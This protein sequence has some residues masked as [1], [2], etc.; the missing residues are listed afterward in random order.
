MPFRWLADLVVVLH[1]LF[2]AFALFGGLLARRWPRAAWLHLPAAAW[3]VLM[4]YAGWPCPL[5]PLEQWLRRQAGEAGY[6]GGFVEH[7]LLPLLY[8]PELPPPTRWLLG[9]VVLA[10]NAA[11]Y[12]CGWRRGR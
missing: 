9:S 8:P 10:V 4:E 11:V 6:A 7:Y 1:L 2:V 12:G 3:A 5:T